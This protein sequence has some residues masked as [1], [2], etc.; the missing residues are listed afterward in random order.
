MKI[1]I[2]EICGEAY[3]GK[4]KPADCPFCGA[5]VAFIKKGSDA[6]PIV[7]QNF[8]IS[9][10]SKKY[11]METFDLEVKA[12]AIYS[13]MSG[14]TANYVIKTMFKR[15]AIIELEHANIVTKILKMDKPQVAEETCP[16]T[17]R[18]NFEKTKE[19]EI[20]A[21]GLYREFAKAAKEPQIRIFFTALAKAE[22][23]H[24]DLADEFLK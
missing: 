15:L 16:D 3:I 6:V 4:E 17:D 10:Q 12:S 13:C 14:K 23:G 24:L 21:S 20:H 19:L 1:F 5:L 8:E 2:C 7:N 22:E 9:E 11:L 18:E